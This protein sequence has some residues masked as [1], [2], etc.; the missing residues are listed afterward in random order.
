MF[1]KSSFYLN[2]NHQELYEFLSFKL[3]D[4]RHFSY[5]IYLVAIKLYNKRI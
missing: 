2:L 3:K 4:S 1:L 5:Y